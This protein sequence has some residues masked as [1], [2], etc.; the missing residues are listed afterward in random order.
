MGYDRGG[1]FFAL[2][3]FTHGSDVESGFGLEGLIET[4]LICWQSSEE[5]VCL[6]AFDGCKVIGEGG[7][8][9]VGV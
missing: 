9:G 4:G 8:G 7:F 2:R 5:F 6:T 3:Q 1:G